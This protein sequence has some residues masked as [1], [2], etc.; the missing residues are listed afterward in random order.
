MINL[1]RKLQPNQTPA[2]LYR[3]LHKQHMLSP[4]EICKLIIDMLDDQRDPQSTA[5][6][7]LDPVMQTKLRY[8][9]TSELEYRRII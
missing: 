6:K 1:T 5:H 9:D 8:F 7:L 3:D 2:T 4:E